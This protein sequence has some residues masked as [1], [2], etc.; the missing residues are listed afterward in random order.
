MVTSRSNV[1]PAVALWV[2]TGLAAAMFFKAASQLL[3]PITIAV[4]ISYA[5]EPLVV[6][7]ERVRVPRLLGAALLLLVL[8]GVVGW[9]VYALRDEVKEAMQAVPEA[10]R[11]AGEWL[12]IGDP[13]RQVEGATSSFPLIQQGLGWLVS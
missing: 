10:M 11:R 3:I 7:L 12:G 2:L 6:R 13:T 5:L 4:L 8:V 1:T 9:G